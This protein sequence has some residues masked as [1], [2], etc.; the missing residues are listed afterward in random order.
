MSVE[1]IRNNWA[2]YMI[3]Q[4]DPRSAEMTKFGDTYALSDYNLSEAKNDAAVAAE[5][6]AAKGLPLQFIV[7]RV[8]SVTTY[9]PTTERPT[10]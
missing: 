4:F 9:G 1:E 8:E 2:H 5:Q 6:A 10:R 3:M 7:V